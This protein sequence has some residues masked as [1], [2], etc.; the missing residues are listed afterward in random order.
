MSKPTK[1][2]S[3]APAKGA[4]G[5]GAIGQQGAL[6]QGALGASGAL[7]TGRAPGRVPARAPANVSEAGTSSS[8][9]SDEDEHKADGR[10]E[11]EQDTQHGALGDDTAD[12]ESSVLGQQ[13]QAT[14]AR[15]QQGA[16]DSAEQLRQMMAQMTMM[17]D[18]MSRMTAAGGSWQ[19]AGQAPGRRGAPAAAA[20]ARAGAPAQA[21]QRAAVTP[22]KELTYAS[23][24]VTVQLEEWLYQIEKFNARMAV[25]EDAAQITEALYAMDRDLNQWWDAH[26]TEAIQTAM[27]TRGAPMQVAERDVDVWDVFC[28]ALREQFVAVHDQELAVDAVFEVRQKAGERMEDYFLRASQVYRRGHRAMDDRTFAR[29]VLGRIRRDEWPFTFSKARTAFAAGQVVSFMQ[30]RTLMTREALS[31][32]GK[33]GTR[34]P[35]QAQA[36]Q[37]QGAQHKGARPGSDRYGVKKRTSVAAAGY[38]APDQEE[39][40][41]EAEDGEEQAPARINATERRDDGTAREGCFRCGKQGHYKRECPEPPKQ[42]GHCYVCG[43]VGAGHY[44]G[45]CPERKGPNGAKP[46]A[47]AAAKKGTPGSKNA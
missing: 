16:P 18:A 44:A 24:Q 40:S 26:R 21:T 7:D 34:A 27:R 41:G 13:A 8:A 28:D 11:D 12:G 42:T 46:A 25:V 3:G 43:K 4:P 17:Q 15:R 6:G 5:P 32:P 39:E 36:Q 20:G 35:A 10:D 37:Q 1:G 14:A 38:S 22:P 33:S 47:A 9:G 2:T 31:E 23:A 45:T 29:Q 30:L 19:L